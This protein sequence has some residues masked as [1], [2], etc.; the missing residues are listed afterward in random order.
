[1]LAKSTFNSIEVLICKAL[2]D[3]VINHDKFILINS[4]LKEYNELK[5]QIKNL[6]TWSSLSK[7]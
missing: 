4:V 5:E 6:K 1:M 7:V 2:I 3:S